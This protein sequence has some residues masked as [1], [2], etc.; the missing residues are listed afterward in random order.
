MYRWLRYMALETRN[1]NKMLREVSPSLGIVNTGH[2]A[3]QCNGCMAPHPGYQAGEKS[4][5]GKDLLWDP[6][7]VSS[8]FVKVAPQ[9]SRSSESTWVGQP[10]WAFL[11]QNGGTQPEGRRPADGWVSPTSAAP[12]LPFS[13]HIR[14]MEQLL[15]PYLDTET[16]LGSR[17]WKACSC[18]TMSSE[19]ALIEWPLWKTSHTPWQ[20]VKTCSK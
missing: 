9:Q 14:C 1:M 7:M 13:D 10:S 20:Q 16:L 4:P 19:W 5:F 12:W 11:Q 6:S 8:L 2:I 17:R 18:M 15:I 3:Q